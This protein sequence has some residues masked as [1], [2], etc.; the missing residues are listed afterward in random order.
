MIFVAYKSFRGAAGLLLPFLHNSPL[1][2]PSECESI[3]LSFKE[4]RSRTKTSRCLV[5]TNTQLET[6][7][8]FK[9]KQ[10]ETRIVLFND[11]VCW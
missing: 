1:R 6:L 8:D 9:L 3:H 11:V 7:P 10:R 2:N 4:N 5:S